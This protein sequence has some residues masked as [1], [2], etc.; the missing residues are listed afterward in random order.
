MSSCSQSNLNIA[1]FNCHSIKNSLSDVVKLC[2]TYDIVCLRRGTGFFQMN[3][4]IL[5]LYMEIF[6]ELVFL[7][8]TSVLV[9]Y[10]VVLM[11]AQVFYIERILRKQSY[12]LTLIILGF[13]L[14]KSAHLNLLF[15]Y[16]VYICQWTMVTMIA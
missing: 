5:P 8:S 3:Y 15:Y 13:A 14:L 16:F 4:N 1:S 9:F 10:T 6:T 11:A 7:Q 2:S 12:L